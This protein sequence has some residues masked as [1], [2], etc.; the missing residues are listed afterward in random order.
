MPPSR[1]PTLAKGVSQALFY[2]KVVPGNMTR[3]GS[4]DLK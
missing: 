2:K 4:A 1:R 3:R